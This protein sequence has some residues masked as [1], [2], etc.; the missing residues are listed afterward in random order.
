VETSAS[1]ARAELERAMSK[2]GEATVK[3]YDRIEPLLALDKPSV[4]AL[5]DEL[6]PKEDAIDTMEEEIVQYCG[7]LAQAGVN[8]N[9]SRSLEL[10]DEIESIADSAV[11]IAHLLERRALAGHD[12]GTEANAELG[13][14]GTKVGEALRATV[15]AIKD[16]H[17]APLETATALVEVAKEAR[18]HAR[19]QQAKV[20]EKVYSENATAGVLYTEMIGKL[21]FV[22]GRCE[23]I[24]DALGRA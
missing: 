1:S 10:I 11:G 17:E 21:S 23:N 13:S 16:R 4:A 3:M 20:L 5:V 15:R 7:Y 6:Q 19:K 14:V 22:V 9:V 24:I 2:V 12:W 18:N 8:F